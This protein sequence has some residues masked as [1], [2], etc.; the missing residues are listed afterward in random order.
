MPCRHATVTHCLSPPPT[1]HKRFLN[2]AK[3]HAATTTHLPSQPMLK[4]ACHAQCCHPVLM[5]CHR[6]TC[7]SIHLTK[8]TITPTTQAT[9]SLGI[10]KH[11]MSLLTLSNRKGWLLAVPHA[12]GRVA[13]SAHGE[14][15]SCLPKGRR[16]CAAQ[17]ACTTELPERHATTMKT[18][19]WG[20]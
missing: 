9:G 10:H 19:A 18:P 17:A 1:T 15:V 4:H 3:H 8:Q 11:R 2:P 13:G 6:Q 20:H 14:G 7:Y 16:F 5:S 12:E